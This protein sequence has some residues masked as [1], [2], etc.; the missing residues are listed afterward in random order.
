[1]PANS[2]EELLAETQA[3]AQRVADDSAAMDRAYLT[4]N[5]QQWFESYADREIAKF[6]AE[7]APA[8]GSQ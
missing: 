6:T 7:P 1:M 4:G 3:N 2:V 8:E 5:Y